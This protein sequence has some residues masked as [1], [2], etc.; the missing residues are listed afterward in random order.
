[1]KPSAASSFII[2]NSACAFSLRGSRRTVSPELNTRYS[3]VAPEAVGFGGGLGDLDLVAQAIA[4]VPVPR[5]ADQLRMQG[6]DM[7]AQAVH[8]RAGRDQPPDE[9]FDEQQH[10]ALERGLVQEPGL[11]GGEA[12]GRGGGGGAPRRPTHQGHR[13]GILSRRRVEIFRRGGRRLGNHGHGVH[14]TT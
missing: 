5:E 10:V 1:M 11:D 13:D 3:G 2:A 12:G 4:A 6:A 8:R 14:H 7:Q 9:G